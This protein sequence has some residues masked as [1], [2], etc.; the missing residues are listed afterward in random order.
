MTEGHLISG[1]S[2]QSRGR[3]P[4]KPVTLSRC[5]GAYE[6]SSDGRKILSWPMGNYG[7]LLGYPSEDNELTDEWS[8]HFS[9]Y[10]YEG[11]LS[12]GSY[13][14]L[15]EQRLANKLASIYAPYLRHKDIGIR[16]FQN[17]TDSCQAAVA[18]CRYATH[19]DMFTSIGYHGGSSP[20]FA[21]EPQNMG[22]LHENSHVRFDVSF[23]HIDDEDF[24]CDACVIVEVP[25]VEDE[26]QAANTLKH[27]ESMCIADDIP[28]IMD[29][30]V[31]G[32][33]FSPAGALQYYSK[34]LNPTIDYVEG[35][36]PEISSWKPSQNI[37]ADFICLGKAMSTYGKVSA[38]L[39]PLDAMEA[40]IQYVF[41]SYTYN[42]HPLGFYDALWTLEQYEKYDEEL[43]HFALVGS[44]GD[45]G[46]ALKDGLNKLFAQY[47]FPAK[48]IGH[49]SRSAI[50]PTDDSGMLDTLLA[51]VVDEHNVLLHRPQFVTLAHTL[52]DVT[53]TLM[54]VEAVLKSWK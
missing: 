53:K 26:L 54:A 17:G 4:G 42:D 1:A 20:V 8:S 3:R 29:E 24:E 46:L 43:Y 21:F 6:Y 32:F 22:V 47:N 52:D 44:V 15:A 16:F 11:H 50:V 27:I 7:P 41:A 12:L 10:M 40:L 13:A 49:P 38:L 30:I 37:K 34:L 5:S 25:S 18:L 35:E 48:C 2:T 33:R 19:R 28:L 31:T 9:D 23:D 45:I 51:R 36:M 14:P 39:G